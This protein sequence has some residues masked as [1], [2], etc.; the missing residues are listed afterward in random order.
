MK[1]K[2]AKRV[3]L[4]LKI[5]LAVV[6]LVWVLSKAHWGDYVLAKDGSTWSWLPAEG[7]TT[8]FV[9]E[10]YLQAVMRGRLKERETRE[11]RP[12]EFVP[13]SEQ[14]SQRDL[15]ARYVRPGL[16]SSLRHINLTL[17]ALAAVCFPLSLLVVGYRF[18]YLLLI[19]NIRIGLWEAIRLTFLGQFF[20]MVV[21]G[22]VGGDLVK[23]WY[24]SRHTH[25]TAGVIITIFADRLFG[26]LE[27]VLMAGG[28]LTFVLATGL[29]SP[30]RMKSSIIT[31]VVSAAITA[32]ML[33][34]FFS[35]RLR[36][37]PGLHW[38]CE[39][40]SITHHLRA[41]GQSVR[42][43]KRRPSFVFWTLLITLVGHLL[44][45]GGIALI[46]QALGLGV[47]AY[48]YFVY[49]PLIYI[50]GAIPITPGGVGWVENLFVEFFRA[51]AAA[52]S[53]IVALAML[54]RLL[55]VF[56]GLPGLV[57]AITGPKLPKADQMQEQLDHAEAEEE[58]EQGDASS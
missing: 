31:V 57:V 21:P 4:V 47:P 37:L 45:L 52:L 9:S 14:A 38:L 56:W 44:F 51:T 58:K 25:K 20:N 32:V 41:A 35:Q 16:A 53:G 34:M 36:R 28:M 50:L 40:L 7:S 15:A 10:S 48:L 29:E 19:Q 33:A 23:A 12:E 22:T 11:F 43:F 39:R 27:L 49:L 26:L 1:K 55:P 2:L 54:A 8:Q 6:L 30:V 13:V 17:F 24:V 42:I 3:F 46:G 18:W 5:A